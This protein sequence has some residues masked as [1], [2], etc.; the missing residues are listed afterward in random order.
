MYRNMSF[1]VML[2]LSLFLFQVETKADIN[3]ARS[4]LY[5]SGEVPPW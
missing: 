1:I 2:C 4:P 5:I 3:L